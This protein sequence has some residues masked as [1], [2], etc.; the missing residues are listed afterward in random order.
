[1]KTMPNFITRLKRRETE[2]LNIDIGFTNGFFKT[3]YTRLHSKEYQI[4]QKLYE[5]K[6][7]LD[8]HIKKLLDGD[9]DAGNATALD[10][11]IEDTVASA[12]EDINTQRAE[13][14]KLIRD[15]GSR[16]AGDECDANLKL[17]DFKKELEETENELAQARE[18]FRM[19]NAP[20]KRNCSQRKD[21]PVFKIER[22]G[23]MNNVS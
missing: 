9:I 18:L 13:H 3:P 15:L 23:G 16:W 10:N 12:V 2:K 20:K 19:V 21:D 5:F 22:N 14:R 11:L 7:E 1:M 8:G 17:A 6:T 4:L